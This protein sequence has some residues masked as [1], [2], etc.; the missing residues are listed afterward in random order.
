MFV[1]LLIAVLLEFVQL[2][3]FVFGFVVLL[4]F[5]GYVAIGCS[6]CV[7]RCVSFV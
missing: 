2:C 4:V 5:V 3:L 7:F 1:C 6:V